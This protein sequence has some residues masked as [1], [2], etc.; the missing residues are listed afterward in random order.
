MRYIQ[1]V[2]LHWRRFV[3]KLD[4]GT[5]C[6]QCNGHRQR[7]A[8]SRK[9]EL[10]LH[11]Q[12]LSRV[13]HHNARYVRTG[14]PHFLRFLPSQMPG[15]RNEGGSRPSWNLM[16]VATGRINAAHSILS[17]IYSHLRLAYFHLLHLTENR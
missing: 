1:S 15:G 7:G 13:F 2:R 4:L 5:S 3:P 6:K 8:Y 10:G 16:F 14:G 17:C 11:G 9:K 12:T